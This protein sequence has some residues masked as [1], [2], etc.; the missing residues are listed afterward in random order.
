M[1]HAVTSMGPITM[2]RAFVM[3]RVSQLVL[4]QMLMA[5]LVMPIARTTMFAIQQAIVTIHLPRH[6]TF[7]STED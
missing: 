3:E 7:Q 5:L 4:T 2:V 1:A 6:V